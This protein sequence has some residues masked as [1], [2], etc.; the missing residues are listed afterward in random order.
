MKIKFQ[1]LAI[2]KGQN[3]PELSTK[4]GSAIQYL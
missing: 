3:G 4:D 1:K 2:T